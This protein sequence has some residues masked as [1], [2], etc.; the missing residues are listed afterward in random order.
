MS[1]TP[2]PIKRSP[3][4]APLSREHHEGLLFV[5]KI[6]QGVRNG[7][8]ATRISCFVQ[9]FWQQHLAAHF[10][11]EERFLPAILTHSHPMMA[12]MFREHAEIKNGVESIAQHGDLKK[13]EQLAQAVDDHIRFEERQLFTEIEKQASPEQLDL[14]STQLVDEKNDTIWEDEFWTKQK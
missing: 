3:Q 6:R 12:Q 14:L 10:E 7:I 5:W 9:W 11:K 4:L 2:T 1:Q 8:E 13:L